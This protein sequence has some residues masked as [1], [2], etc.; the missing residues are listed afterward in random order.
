MKCL[1]NWVMD[2]QFL[3]AA[4]L[5]TWSTKLNSDKSTQCSPYL[6]WPLPKYYLTLRSSDMSD[7]MKNKTLLTSGSAT[8]KYIYSDLHYNYNFSKQIYTTTI[9][10]I[11]RSTLNYVFTKQIYTKTMY[12][13]S[14]STLNYVFT[15]Q[16]YTKTMYLLSRS[17][18]KLLSFRVLPPTRRKTGRASHFHHHLLTPFSPPSLFSFFR[19]IM[20]FSTEFRGY[21]S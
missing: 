11:N 8:T 13:P 17:T 18:L 20:T 7:S 12:L 14:K 16:I 19:I 3:E 9:I 2:P 1:K 4:L 5:I 10:L 15:K 6:I 21:R